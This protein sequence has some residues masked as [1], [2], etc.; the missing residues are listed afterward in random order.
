[1]IRDHLDDRSYPAMSIVA[2]TSR[3]FAGFL[4]IGRDKSGQ[5]FTA[6]EYYE[7][8]QGVSH[9]VKIADLAGGRLIDP[10]TLPAELR[11][12]FLRAFSRLM[13]HLRI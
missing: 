3:A 8:S 4:G 5:L 1:M 12:L 13:L 10:T 7:H 9:E 6:S 11:K 2:L